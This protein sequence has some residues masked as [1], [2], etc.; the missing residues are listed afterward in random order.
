MSKSSNLPD[1]IV[2]AMPDDGNPDWKKGDVVGVGW[3]NERSISV[4]LNRYVV[5]NGEARILL[6]PNAAKEK[7]EG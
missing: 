6:V 7:G 1:W 4:K 2:K 3:S 5:L